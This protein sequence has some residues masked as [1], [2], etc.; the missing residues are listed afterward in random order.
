MNLKF[1]DF[2]E[3]ASNSP[4]QVK[5]QKSY[6]YKHA[7]R[8]YET[9]LLLNKLTKPN[10]DVLSIG[11]G[12][13]FTEYVLS[14]KK[15]LN[16]TVFDFPEVIN[17]NKDQFKESNFST[18]EGNFL[19]DSEKLG[20]KKFDILLFCEILE[21]I[22]VSPKKQL[23][24]VKSYLRPNGFLIISTPN[25]AS[26]FHIITLLRSKNIFSSA[27]EL[28]INPSQK[29][30][31][32]CHRREYTMSEILKYCEACELEIFSKDYVLQGPL[33]RTFFSFLLNIFLKLFK[34]YRPFLLISARKL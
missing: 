24:I 28:F 8:L 18:V 23:E 14:K 19:I 12:K 4:S 30:H 20:N 22:P 10:A 2:I 34:K 7:V 25:V 13:A 29:N 17:N 11:A 9:Y 15:P 32:H 26:I 27:E 3:I 6:L 31:F 21:H 5:N 33:T 16:L 1:K